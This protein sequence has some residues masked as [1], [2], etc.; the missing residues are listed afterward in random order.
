MTI[1][2]TYRKHIL[3]DV[4]ASSSVLRETSVPITPS[5]VCRR[6]LRNLDIDSS[7]QFCAGDEGRDS[8]QGDSGG[9]LSLRS[10]KTPDLFYQIGV[11]SVGPDECGGGSPGI[12]TRVTAFLNWIRSRLRP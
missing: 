9:A 2:A 8:C 12:Y 4:G 10:A 6:T 11:V 5:A 7:V 1:H 3:Q